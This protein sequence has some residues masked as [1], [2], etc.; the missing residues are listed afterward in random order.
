MNLSNPARRSSRI[1]ALFP[2]G[3]VAAELAGVAS[4]ALLLPAEAACVGRMVAARAGEFAGGRLCARLALAGLG[5]ESFAVTAKPDRQ[6][7]WPDGVV[8]SITHT[9]GICAAVVGRGSQYLGLGLDTEIVGRVTEPLAV[10]ICVPSERDWIGS[11][12]AACRAAARTVVFAV[13]EAFYKAQS[14]LTGEWLG[15]DALAVRV[16]GLPAALQAGGC[17]EFLAT[18]TR[19]IRLGQWAQ[20]PWRGGFCLHEGFVSV[21]LALSTPGRPGT[22]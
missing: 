22:P 8:G 9:D 15:F 21:G 6:P 19:A 10:R 18:P 20:P 7:F 13:K 12:P 5:I 2:P 16:P 3:V 17:G 14:P 11:L 4:P 1:E